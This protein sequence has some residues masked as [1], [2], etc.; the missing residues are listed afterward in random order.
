[1][2]FKAQCTSCGQKMKKTMFGNRKGY[3]VV[4]E[5]KRAATIKCKGCGKQRTLQK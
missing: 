3:V 1:M 5:G 2:G 4:S